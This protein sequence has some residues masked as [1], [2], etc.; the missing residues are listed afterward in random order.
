[1]IQ[2]DISHLGFILAAVKEETIMVKIIFNGKAETVAEEETLHSFLSKHQLAGKNLIIEWNGKIFTEN[3]SLES[4]SLHSGDE[5][6][7][8]SMVGG[9]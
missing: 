2:L 8:F 7:L 6:N 3:D 5:L 9:G 4:F 1:M